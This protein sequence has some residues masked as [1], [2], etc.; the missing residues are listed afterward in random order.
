MSKPTPLRTIHARN[1][2]PRE[3][4]DWVTTHELLNEA[5]ITYRQADYWTRTRLLTPIEAHTPGSGH[6]R[7]YRADQVDRARAL[8]AL[9]DAGVS[10]ITCRLVIDEVL[11]TG[12]ATVGG[13]TLHLNP[14]STGATPA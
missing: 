6:L 4:R 10:L 11:A 5:D 13:V 3:D 2:P 1:L 12:T 9:L 8:A 7:R 14:P